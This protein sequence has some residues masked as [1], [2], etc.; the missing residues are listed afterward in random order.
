MCFVW[1][2]ILFALGDFND[3]RGSSMK[4]PDGH[5]AVDFDLRYRRF[6]LKMLRARSAIEDGADRAR[7]DSSDNSASLRVLFPFLNLI[8]CMAGGAHSASRYSL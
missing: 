4:S 1:I 6:A 8:A 5:L 7:L 2:L 3:V